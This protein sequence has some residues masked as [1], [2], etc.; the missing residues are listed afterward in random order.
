MKSPDDAVNLQHV[1]DSYCLC[2]DMQVNSIEQ[3]RT[4]KVIECAGIRDR[5]TRP[6]RVI[7]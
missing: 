4:L 5:Q 6:G 1:T 2:C 3:N 7:G